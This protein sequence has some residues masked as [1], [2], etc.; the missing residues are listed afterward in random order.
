MEDNRQKEFIFSDEFD[1]DTIIEE[2][3]GLES[4]NGDRNIENDEEEQTQQPGESIEQDAKDEVNDR[5]TVDK[6]GE[7]KAPEPSIKISRSFRVKPEMMYKPVE[8]NKDYGDD[9]E[10]L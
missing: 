10:K 4:I 1:K 5:I 9:L 8:H 2:K 3:P 6:P 7:E